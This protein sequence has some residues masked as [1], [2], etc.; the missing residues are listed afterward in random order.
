MLEQRLRQL[1]ETDSLNGDRAKDLKQV[2]GTR[3][4]HAAIL[5]HSDCCQVD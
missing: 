3:R 1:V 5:S 2:A 4:V